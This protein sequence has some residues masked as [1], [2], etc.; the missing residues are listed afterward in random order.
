MLN[1]SLTSTVHLTTRLPGADDVTTPIGTIT[2]DVIA[3][4]VAEQQIREELGALLRH[5][6]DY[7][8]R[9]GALPS[10]ATPAPAD[11]T[12]LAGAAGVGELG[13]PG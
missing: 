6:G 2:V 3:G 1:A 4:V 5:A 8:L 12:V 7:L 9:T 13:S 11:D 10:P